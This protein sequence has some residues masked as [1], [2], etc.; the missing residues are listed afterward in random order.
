MYVP[1]NSDSYNNVFKALKGK[2]ELDITELKQYLEKR[3]QVA[4]TASPP[5]LKNNITK[6]VTPASPVWKLSK[7]NILAL[8]K[9]IE[10]VK[11]KSYS[12]STIRTYRNEFLQLLQ[13]LK[14]YS[15][16]DLTPNDLRRNMVF[17]REKESIRRIRHLVGALYPVEFIK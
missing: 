16:N 8:E 14:N 13:L 9:F 1:L 7:E 10:Q 6:S 12:P 17:A 2:A 15:V 11:L 3:K 4:A 5:E